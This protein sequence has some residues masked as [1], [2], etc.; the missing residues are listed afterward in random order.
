MDTNTARTLATPGVLDDPVLNRGA[1]FTVAELWSP[2]IPARCRDVRG[3]QR[4]RRAG[5]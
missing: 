5:Q 1:G 4:V 2:R 3:G